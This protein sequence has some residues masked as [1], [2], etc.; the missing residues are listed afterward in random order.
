M[1]AFGPV[2]SRRLGLSLGINNI[3]SPKTCSYNCVYC[4]VGKTYKHVPERQHFYDPQY[5]LKNVDEHLQ[6]LQKSHKPDYLTFVSNGEPTMDMGLGEDILLLKKFN[7]PV[8]VI[9]NSSF[10]YDKN[11]RKELMLADWVSVKMDVLDEN[12]WSRLNRAANGLKLNTVLRGVKEF[13]SEY[14]GQLHTETMLVEGFND[15]LEHLQ[16]LANFISELQPQKAFLSI[17]TRPSAENNVKPVN[18]AVLLEAW[19]IF[20]NAA[21]TTELL[22]GFEGTNVGFTG[23]V[24]DDILNIT[25]VHPLREDSMTEL[26]KNNKADM[27]VVHSLISQRLIESIKHDGMNY[28]VRKYNIIK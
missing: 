7:I 27:S 6:K 26:L 18:E 21:I 17:P 4:Q 3:T 28:Y 13:A 12:I 10:L 1:I 22:T 14:H 16:E 8:A 25:A 9:T 19:Q 15:S 24:F 23:N 2:L 20:T 11:V 5:L